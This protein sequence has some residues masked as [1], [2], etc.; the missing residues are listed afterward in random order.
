MSIYFDTHILGGSFSVLP[1][2][3]H[4]KS[5]QSKWSFIESAPVEI[6]DSIFSEF[7]ALSKQQK[8]ESAART[9]RS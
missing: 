1:V 2:K 6:G 3:I 8:R 9:D 5:F 7:S 4:L